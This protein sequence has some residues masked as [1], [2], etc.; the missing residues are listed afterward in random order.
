MSKS[1]LL[2][3]MILAA[4]FLLRRSRKSEKRRTYE[5]KPQTPWADL[6]EDKDPTL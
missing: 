2:M 5:R 1:A 6:N 4:G 3:V